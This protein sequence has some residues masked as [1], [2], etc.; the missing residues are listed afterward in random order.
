MGNRSRHKSRHQ[1]TVP[2]GLPLAQVMR[3]HC[4]ECGAP[5]EWLT[6][7]EANARSLDLGPALQLLGVSE[8]AEVWACPQCAN[9]GVMGP[10]E[11]GTL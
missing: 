2:L 3:T 9:F 11:Y 5:V 4:N 6:A 1:R 8:P 7:E 10:S